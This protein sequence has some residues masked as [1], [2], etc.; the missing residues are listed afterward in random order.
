MMAF[1]LDNILAIATSDDTKLYNINT[2]TFIHTLPRGGVNIP[3]AFSPDCTRLAVGDFGGNVNLWDIRGIDT[4]G[5]PSTGN[6]TAVTALTLSRDC[7]RLACGF[8]D[9]TVELWETSP[10]KRRIDP[11]PLRSAREPNFIR[12]FRHQTY[13]SAVR[14]LG[15][16]PD[17]RLFASGSDDGTIK[18][19]NGG[20]GVLRG[21]LKALSGVRAVALSNSVLVATWGGWDDNWWDYGVTLWSLDTLRPIHTFYDRAD[22]S[23][24]SIAENGTLIAVCF[25]SHVTLFDVA[26]RTTIRTFAVVSNIHTMTFLPDNSHLMVQSDKGVFRSFNLINNHTTEGPT[27]EHLVQLPNTPLLHGVPVLH[28]KEQEQHYFAALFSQHKSPMPVLWI[29]KQISVTKWTQGSSMIA[30]SCEDGRVILLR[31]PTSHV[32]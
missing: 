29:P 7:S 1:S 27:L 5:P 30:L 6:A 2:H 9:S 21:T 32:S 14:A 3:P 18:L 26:N 24:V 17:G 19:W 28:C 12:I 8:E 13:Y 23:K 15:F 22:A 11:L 31:L 25:D 4:S 10:T 16:D 20:D